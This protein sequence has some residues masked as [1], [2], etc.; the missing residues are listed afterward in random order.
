METHQD[1]PKAGEDPWHTVT[2]EFSGLGRRLRETYRRVAEEDG[3]SEDQI[4]EALATLGAAWSQVSGSVGAALQNPEVRDHLKAAA[5]AF[6]SA[7]GSTVSELGVELR[8]D[9]AGSEEE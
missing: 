1:D 4:R 8:R 5:G 9:D 2:S 6:A 3:P 7:I